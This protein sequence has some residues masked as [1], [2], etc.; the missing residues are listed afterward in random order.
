MEEIRELAEIT[1]KSTSSVENSPAYQKGNTSF[2]SRKNPFMT[3][4]SEIQSIKDVLTHFQ[5]QI[6]VLSSSVE[7]KVLEV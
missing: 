2:E 7:S 6:N 1:P 3:E 5:K 4:S